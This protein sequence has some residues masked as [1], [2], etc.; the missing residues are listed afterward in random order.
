MDQI[1]PSP[2]LEL[3][4]HRLGIRGQ[5]FVLFP[6]SDAWPNPRIC[7][8][9]MKIIH[10]PKM[11]KSKISLTKRFHKKHE[12]YVGPLAMGPYLLTF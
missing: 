11:A 2:D 8:F 10:T 5:G 7:K 6:N 12:F 4:P 3:V 9:V 1:D